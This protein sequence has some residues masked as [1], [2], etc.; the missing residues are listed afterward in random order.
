MDNDVILTHLVINAIF[1]TSSSTSE[2]S[3]SS[4]NE[5]T[6]FKRVL[7]W[8]VV[9][10]AGYCAGIFSEVVGGGGDEGL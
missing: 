8:F 7:V 4:R 1:N 5:D 2:S 3:M 10:M 9:L 6:L